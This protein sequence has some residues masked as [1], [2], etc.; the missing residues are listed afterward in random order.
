MENNVDFELMSQFLTYYNKLR[1]KVMLHPE[2]KFGKNNYHLLSEEAKEAK[3]IFDYI[4]RLFDLNSDLKK[5]ETF[6]RRFPNKKYYESNDINQLDYIKYHY[7]V[8][9]HKINTIKEVM[10]LLLNEFY[11]I[12]LNEKDCTWSNLKKHKK[13]KNSSTIQIVEFYY[14]TFNHLI[15][16]RNL[17]THRGYFKDSRNEDLK[18]DLLIHNYLEMDEG[19]LKKDFA[20]IKPKFIVDFQIKKYRKE[21]LKY[22]KDGQKVAETYINQ[23]ITLI[24]N[25]FFHNKL[26][27]N[28]E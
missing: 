8:Y 22:V 12:G 24:L 16:L 2:F 27:M 23:F 1:K 20:R 25:E 13:I 7:E 5:I 11:K 14:K 9:I 19:N 4:G 10:I 15:K 21:R 17:N 26:N 28:Q 6:I 18:S 3:G